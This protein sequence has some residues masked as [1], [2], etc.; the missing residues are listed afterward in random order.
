MKYTKA[1]LCLLLCGILLC[2]AGCGQ[3][4]PVVDEREDRPWATAGETAQ[5]KIPEEEYTHSEEL[6]TLETL[7]TDDSTI[8]LPLGVTADDITKLESILWEPF[9]YA[10]YNNESDS[11]E[12]AM[13]YIGDYARP[14]GLMEIY[15]KLDPEHT[16]GE[17]ELVSIVDE[18]DPMELFPD[19][20][21]KVDASV[22][23]F[24]VEDVFQNVSNHRLRTDNFYC[25]GDYFYMN[26]LPSGVTP[27]EA[28]VR[29]CQSLDNGHYRLTVES[30]ILDE[31][32][33]EPI[34]NKSA[35]IE[36][37]IVQTGN[38]RHWTIFS[39]E[40]FE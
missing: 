40:T 25:R 39:V 29:A 32:T 17:Y 22:I 38:L 33:D 19:E 4:E 9:F 34:H 18:P 26:F 8:T 12:E 2:Y 27:V 31:L 16:H 13:R 30:F 1:A 10:D 6:V 5:R 14:L 3:Q 20:Y 23:D 7:I 24:L 21:Y 11:M 36:A 15:D 28:H 35:F 37:A